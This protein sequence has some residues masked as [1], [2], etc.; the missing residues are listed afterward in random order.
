MTE[1]Q[2]NLAAALVAFQ[3]SAPSINK[4]RTALIPTKSGGSYS[5]KYADLSDIWDAIREPLKANDL[6]VTQSLTGGSSGF[7]GIRTTVWH[8]SG[9]CVSDTVE[10]AINSRTPQEVGSQVT[11][12]K[13]YA[14]SALLGLSTEEDDDGAAASRPRPEPQREPD[15]FEVARKELAVKAKELGYTPT[16]LED[17]CLEEMKEPITAEKIRAFIKLLD[18]A[19]S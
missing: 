2:P 10:L 18:G 13:R 14:L 17:R 6:A 5:Y 16:G 4:G 15:D 12:F 7:M 19:A 1:L 9:Q 11:Y 3:A 8:K